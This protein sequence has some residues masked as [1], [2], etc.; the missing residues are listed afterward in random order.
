MIGNMKGS[1]FDAA[2]FYKNLDGLRDIIKNNPALAGISDQFETSVATINGQTFTIEKRNS[3]KV[4]ESGYY[5]YPPGMVITI[6]GSNRYTVPENGLVYITA[7]SGIEY[8][9]IIYPNLTFGQMA[10]MGGYDVINA[11]VSPKDKDGNPLT[12]WDSTISQ[13]I[14][15][16]LT[17]ITTLVGS[18]SS[19]LQAVM[20]QDIS[21]RT[22]LENFIKEGLKS[23]TDMN[24]TIMRNISAVTR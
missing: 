14:L 13:N 1:S 10:A 6:N 9:S 7:G 20:Q 3:F 21:T 12:G 4:Q 22:A 24:Q 8:S 18:P 16:T 19:A 11:Q 15:S 2:S 23:I 17:S 5:S